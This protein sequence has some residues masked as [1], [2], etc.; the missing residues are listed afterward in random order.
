MLITTPTSG[1]SHT[2]SRHYSSVDIVLG[3][4][5][6]YGDRVRSQCRLAFSMAQ[7]GSYAAAQESLQSLHSQIKGTLKLEQRVASFA[8]LIA[9]LQSIRKYV[10]Q[11]SIK[12]SKT[13][14]DFMLT[15]PRSQLQPPSRAH[16]PI[17]LSPPLPNLRPRPLAPN[18][19]PR[20]RPPDAPF[21]PQSPQSLPEDLRSPRR[22]AR[23][24][25]HP[26]PPHA[27]SRRVCRSRQ[28]RERLQHSGASSQ[29]RRARGLTTG[30]AGGAGR[31]GRDSQQGWGVWGE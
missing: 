22:K 19:P 24:R 6:S 9:L 26:P 28:T 3:K 10:P 12:F 7:N 4:E 17:P 31:F 13:S 5:C 27:Q 20:N 1:Q 23:S 29:S 8:R 21:W 18:L 25:S 14:P 11:H 2:A 16:P 30:V 15:S